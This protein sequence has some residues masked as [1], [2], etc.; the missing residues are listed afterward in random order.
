MKG[1]YRIPQT[2]PIPAAPEVILHL[3]I[4]HLMSRWNLTLGSTHV[5]FLTPSISKIWAKIVISLSVVQPG[6]RK[7]I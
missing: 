5:F 6:S 1:P 4:Q 3:D 2:R 7:C